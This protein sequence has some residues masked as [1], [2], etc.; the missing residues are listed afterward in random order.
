M[1]AKHG[2]W[3]KEVIQPRASGHGGQVK[4][5]YIVTDWS[6]CCKSRTWKSVMPFR[7]DWPPPPI[8]CKFRILFIQIN[9]N[10]MTLI[11]LI[12]IR[13]LWFV[14][15]YFWLNCEVR[16]NGRIWGWV[17][18]RRV[19]DGD[20]SSLNG[21]FLNCRKSIT[22]YVLHQSSPKDLSNF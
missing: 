15:V 8:A 3:G 1:S 16:S 12:I 20:L 14:K 2:I 10:K 19:A 13:K 7:F 21:L 11:K 5:I 22:P 17:W 18:M 9:A 6:L 4:Q